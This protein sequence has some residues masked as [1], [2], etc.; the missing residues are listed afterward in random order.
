[1][2]SDL[3]ITE[4]LISA[5]MLLQLLQFAI[6]SDA[7]AALREASF[8]NFRKVLAERRWQ[9]TLL[10]PRAFG[11]N[12]IQGWRGRSCE[13][14]PEKPLW[15]AASKGTF[16]CV[17]WECVTEVGEQRAQL[18]GRAVKGNRIRA[19]RGAVR[20]G[21]CKQRVLPALRSHV[22]Q[23]CLGALSRGQRS[24]RCGAPLG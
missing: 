4:L 6:R 12:F 15:T 3:M 22:T 19:A 24:A 9:G 13:T 7:L 16:A 2:M 14:I 18:R 10:A 5:L 21:N 11:G 8:L 20:V 17:I 23:L 1:M